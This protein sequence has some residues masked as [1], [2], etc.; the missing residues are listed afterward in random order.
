MHYEDGDT[1]YEEAKSD[2][3]LCQSDAEALELDK[4]YP[5]MTRF[6]DEPFQYYLYTVACRKSNIFAKTI[7]AWR[8]DALHSTLHK[9]K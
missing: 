5:T 1:K 7:Q 8:N 3:A 2:M 9:D 4:N 6:L